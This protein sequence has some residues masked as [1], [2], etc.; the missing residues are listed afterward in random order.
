MNITTITQ[1]LELGGAA[2]MALGIFGHALVALP[3]PWA[4]RIGK[5]CEG[6]GVDVKRISEAFRKVEVK[7]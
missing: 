4:Q 5:A 6:I 3:W 2:A 1:V 7:K